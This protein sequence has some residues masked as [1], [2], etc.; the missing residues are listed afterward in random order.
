MIRENGGSG[1]LKSALRYSTEHDSGDRR[2]KHPANDA[3]DA[4][5]EPPKFWRVARLYN[6][7][8]SACQCG[9]GG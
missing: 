7:I 1:V 2:A 9:C 4:M 3:R 5:R 6:W 8:Y